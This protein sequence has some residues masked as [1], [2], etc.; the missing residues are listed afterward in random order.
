MINWELVKYIEEN[1]IPKYKKNEDGHN[2]SHINYVTK[3]CINF[4]K[5]INIDLNIIYTCASFHDLCHYI[6]KDKHEILSAEY[7]FNDEK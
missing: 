5:Q 4:G 2:E 6:D 3:R 7:F 1:I